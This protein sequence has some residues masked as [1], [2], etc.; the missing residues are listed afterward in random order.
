MYN[1]NQCY[2]PRPYGS[3]GNCVSEL[4]LFLLSEKFIFLMGADDP[5]VLTPFT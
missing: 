2:L 5:E 1:T 4:I 3:L